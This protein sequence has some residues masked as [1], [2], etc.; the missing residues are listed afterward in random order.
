MRVANLSGRTVLID[1]D[2]AVDVHTASA[3][4]FGPDPAAVYAEWPAFADWARSA[5]GTAAG[6]AFDGRHLGAPSPAPSQVFA[7][8][9]NYRDHAAETGLDAPDAPPTFTKFAS[10]L[11]GPDTDL[12]LPTDTVDWEVELVAVIGR[13][14]TGVAADD[15]WA[16]VAGLTVGQ[17]FSERTSQMAGP[18]PQFSLAKS[19]P[20]FGATGPWLVTPDEFADRDDLAIAC[21][22]DGETVQSGRTAQMMFPVAELIARLSAVCTLRPGDLIFTGTPAG[23]GV[24]RSPQRFLVPGN[25]VISSI[26]GIGSLV[27]RCVPG[28]R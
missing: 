27:Q 13:E 11:T 25:V 24:G 9:L 19:F 8:G 23:V 10:C 15:A 7:I 3:G 1:D 6:E 16:Y 20:G 21:E 5:S 17:D 2:R 4:R 12:P 26:E 18:A 28:S 22:I 14:A